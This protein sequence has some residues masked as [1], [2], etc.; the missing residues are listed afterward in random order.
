MRLLEVH[1]EKAPVVRLAGRHHHVVDRGQHFTEEKFKGS[2][3]VASKAAVLSASSSL[4]APEGLGIPAH[5]E[6][7]RTMSSER[8]GHLIGRTL[9][10][11]DEDRVARNP[12][13][14]H[15]PMFFEDYR[16][17]GTGA[18]T[19]ARI[20]IALSSYALTSPHHRER[21]DIGSIC[22]QGIAHL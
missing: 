13:Y 19:R 15:C 16:G 14:S 10:S 3:S 12:V 17:D 22:E 6:Q 4:A 18:D 2:G 7:C 20:Q 21:L 5:S 11:N 9:R 1:V 8:R